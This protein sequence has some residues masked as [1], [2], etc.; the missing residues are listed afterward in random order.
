MK[1]LSVP[2]MQ[3]GKQYIKHI[4][5][6]SNRRENP[7][8]CPAGFLWMIRVIV[9]FGST[10]QMEHEARLTHFSM[11]LSIGSGALHRD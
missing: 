1:E 6:H 9:Q 7:E 4:V 3:Q 5:W 11:C 2:E 10:R 8:Q